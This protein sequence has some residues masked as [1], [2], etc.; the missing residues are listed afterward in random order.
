MRNI[1]HAVYQEL[2]KRADVRHFPCVY[3]HKNGELCEIIAV[4]FSL[5]ARLGSISSTIKKKKKKT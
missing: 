4:S 5:T 3:T 1:V 2:A